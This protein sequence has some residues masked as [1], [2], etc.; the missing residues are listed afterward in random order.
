LPT[1]EFVYIPVRTQWVPEVFAH[2]AELENGERSVT[3]E[4][5]A[6]NGGQPSGND[7]SLDRALLERM[8]RESH[9]P[10]RRLME[11]LAEHAGELIYTSDLAARLGLAHGARS[12]AGML[13]AF[14]RRAEHRYGGRKPWESEWDPS[15]YESRHRMTPEVAEQIREIA[16]ATP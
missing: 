10:H 4:E 16:A 14:G 6:Q 15:V 13:G 8:Y 3:V 5:A 11:Y 1:D 12:L 9:G 2:I 7:S